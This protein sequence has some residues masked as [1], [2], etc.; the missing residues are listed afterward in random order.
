MAP[1][2]MAG[3]AQSG[4]AKVKLGIE[5]LQKALPELEMGTPLHTAVLKAVAD[6][7]KAVDKGADDQAAKVQQLMQMARSASAQPNPQGQAMQ[8]MFPQSQQAA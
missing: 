8:Q 6:I 7:G 1:S 2:A 5:A 3:S 4:Q